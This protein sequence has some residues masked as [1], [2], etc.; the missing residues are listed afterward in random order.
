[1]ADE[2]DKIKELLGRAYLLPADHKKRIENALD[3]DIASAEARRIIKIL[4]D[5]IVWQEKT[6]TEVVKNKPNLYKKILKAYNETRHKMAGARASG[7][8]KKDEMHINKI[9]SIIQKL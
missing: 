3:M 1:M 6:V 8:K 9:K 2:R 4:Q 5:F 7:L